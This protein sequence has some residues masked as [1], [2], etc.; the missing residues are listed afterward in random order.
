MSE[1]YI[2]MKT[3]AQIIDEKMRSVK[4]Y[5][6]KNALSDEIVDDIFTMLSTMTDTSV[7]ASALAA[8]QINK[9][10]TN[11]EAAINSLDEAHILMLSCAKPVNPQSA[12]TEGVYTE[13]QPPLW[14][15][16]N[17]YSEEVV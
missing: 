3:P 17:E 1:K 5:F 15:L 12:Y 13:E 16:A 7:S 11:V 4:E 2:H 14:E 10:I 9:A 8:I 6:S